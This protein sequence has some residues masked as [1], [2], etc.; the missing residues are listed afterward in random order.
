MARYYEFT[1]RASGGDEVAVL[2]RCDPDDVQRRVE[3]ARAGGKAEAYAMFEME[4]V[5]LRADVA[6]LRSENDELRAS[7]KKLRE[8]LDR[9]KE[10]R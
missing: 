9:A 3:A 6:R 7:K 8:A 5:V 4:L 1:F 10:G 2:R